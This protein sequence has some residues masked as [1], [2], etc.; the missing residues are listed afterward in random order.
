MILVLDC[1]LFGINVAVLAFIWP[2][3]K[4]IFLC[5]FT[6]SLL[7]DTIQFDHGFE[8]MNLS[9][10]LCPL[11]SIFNPFTFAWFSDNRIGLVYTCFLYI[12]THLHLDGFWFVLVFCYVSN[13][14]FSFSSLLPLLSSSYTVVF[15]LMLLLS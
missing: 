13:V 1:V 6:F 14:C 4:Y 7:E 11:V 15:F 5:P 10:C 12:L 2:F 9:S 3:A 8:K